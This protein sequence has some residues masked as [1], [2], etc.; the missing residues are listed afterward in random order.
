MQSEPLFIGHFGMCFRSIVAFVPGLAYLHSM[1]TVH[2]DIKGANLLVEKNGRVKLADFGM[3]K[4]M[5]EHMSVTRSFKGSAFWMASA[6][7][8]K[9]NIMLAALA[10]PEVIR[11]RGHGVAADIWSV[12]CT[13]LEMATGSPPWSQCSTQAC[14]NLRYGFSTHRDTDMC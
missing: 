11:Q 14:R 7:S 2:R 5:V 1:R 13:V 12:G 10:A 9:S 3:A 4:Q 6:F 8:A